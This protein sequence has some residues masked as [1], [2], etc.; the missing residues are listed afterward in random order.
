MDGKRP[1]LKDVLNNL[2]TTLLMYGAAVLMTLA[3]LVSAPVDTSY[4][5]V[6][7]SN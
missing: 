6:R 5:L 3:G 2:A 4:D 7:L 1:H